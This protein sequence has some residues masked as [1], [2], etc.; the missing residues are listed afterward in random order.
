M[1]PA[2]SVRNK[3]ITQGVKRLVLMEKKKIADNNLTALSLSVIL[4]H[5]FKVIY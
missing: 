4:K 2:P 1:N 5:F 3:D